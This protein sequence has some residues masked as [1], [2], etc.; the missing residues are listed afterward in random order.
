MAKQVD[1]HRPGDR[2]VRT[3]A[4]TNRAGCIAPGG[5]PDLV[6]PSC[7]LLESATGT[8]IVMDPI[9]TNIGYLP[10]ADLRANAVTISHEHP[11]HTNIGLLQG[12]PR[13]LRGL[14]ADKKG[15]VKIDEKIKDIRSARWACTTT[16]SAAPSSAS[17]PC[18]F[19]NR[20]R[21]HR[22]SRRPRAC[23]D[24]RADSAIGS[25]DV[26]LVPVGGTWTIDAQEATHVVDQ[27]RPR[28]VVIPMHYKTD[29]VT[30]KELAPVDAFLA[31]RPNVRREK[32][33]R[34]AITGLRYKPSA[35][36]VVLNYK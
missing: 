16:P 29:V 21:A 31:G 30:I 11:D 10:P 13:I 25:V 1:V 20:R 22:A 12:K 6:W 36:V 24:R 9:P 14:T 23:P 17:T 2:A 32:T 34:V 8:R 27:I 28:L 3:G 5:L 33:N 26:V 7:F 19:R 18:L 4:P 35:E 15:W